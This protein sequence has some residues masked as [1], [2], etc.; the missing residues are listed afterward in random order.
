MEKIRYSYAG[1]DFET[2]VI[3]SKDSDFKLV[4]VALNI[5]FYRRTLNPFNYIFKAI[6]F[7]RRKEALRW[8][9]L[10]F[11]FSWEF[12]YFS[13]SSIFR[14]NKDFLIYLSKNKIKILNFEKTDLAERFIKD[15]QVNLII[16]N[17]WTLLP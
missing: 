12:C 5:A 11:L 8:L 15:N 2:L 9:E 17:A 4:A 10:L 6:Y 3:L 1:L 7:L 14:L 13:S 16:V